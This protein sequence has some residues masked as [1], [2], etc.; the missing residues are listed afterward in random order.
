MLAKGS[1]PRCLNK[2]LNIPNTEYQSYLKN[3]RTKKIF[4][5]ISLYVSLEDLNILPFLFFYFFMAFTKKPERGIKFLKK[6]L[7]RLS[8]HLFYIFFSCKFLCFVFLRTPLGLWVYVQCTLFT[9]HVCTCKG[10]HTHTLV[11]CKDRH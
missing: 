2:F 7:Y 4:I 5:K 8:P 6:I 9:A 10:G 11:L 1:H 3:K